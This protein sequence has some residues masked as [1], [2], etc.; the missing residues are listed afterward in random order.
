[1]TKVF[2]G[3]I[4]DDLIVNKI[5]NNE[6]YIVSN[7]SMAEQDF[8]ILENAAATFDCKLEKIE[9]GLIAVQGPKVKIVI[10]SLAFNRNF[11]SHFNE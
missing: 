2:K 1:M 10:D 11:F 4:L 7:A 3:G 9:T 8:G 6:I 5:S